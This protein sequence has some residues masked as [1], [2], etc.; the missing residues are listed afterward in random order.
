MPVAR[1]NRESFMF[2]TEADR[3]LPKDQQTTFHCRRLPTTTMVRLRDLRDGDQASL[4]TW[5][6][7][8]LATGLQGWTNYRTEDGEQVVFEPLASVR[9]EARSSE[10][11]AICGAMDM[12][13]IA[14]R[15]T[16]DVLAPSDAQEIAMAIFSGNELTAADVP[17]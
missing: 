5:M 7:L 16:L 6:L 17:N 13:Q 14:S 9:K 3:K 1:S 2:V 4:G 8:A 10:A 15:S 12:L 11:I